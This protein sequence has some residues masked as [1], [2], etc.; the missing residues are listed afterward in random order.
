MYKKLDQLESGK[1][2][3]FLAP[4]NDLS[5]EASALYVIE[6]TE[7]G[8]TVRKFAGD[9]FATTDDFI[10]AQHEAEKDFQNRG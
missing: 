5:P 2:Y 8:Y 10:Q 9:Y 7:N 6:D 4:E 1:W 3:Y